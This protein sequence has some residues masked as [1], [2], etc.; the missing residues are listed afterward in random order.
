MKKIIGI[1]MSI[2]LLTSISSLSVVGINASDNK[3][4]EILNTTGHNVILSNGDYTPHENIYIEGDDEFTVENGV[5]GGSGTKG[6]PYVIEG[7]KISKIHVYTTTAYFVI[8]NCYFDEC[9]TDAIA[10]WG[11]TNG[12]VQN[13]TIDGDHEEHQ[14]HLG[15]AIDM[16]NACNNI[17]ENCSITNITLAG[18]RLHPT[19]LGPSNNNIIRNCTISNCGDTTTENTAGI[20]VVYSDSYSKYNM[21]YHNNF[22]DNP[23]YNALDILFSGYSSS[24]T[25]WD[26]GMEGNYWDDYDGPDL[27][28]RDGIGDIPYGI[29]HHPLKTKDRF[30]LMKPYNGTASSIQV[31]QSVPQSN[32]SGQPSSQQTTSTSTTSSTSQTLD[33]VET[34]ES[35][36]GQQ[37]AIPEF[38]L[39]LKFFQQMLLHLKLN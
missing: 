18:I 33:I 4:V 12:R 36:S 28:P 13:C 22:I 25:Q 32:P 24:T 9:I 14:V 26:N 19:E 35:I 31:S 10:F 29:P 5:T 37:S 27:F 6:D 2:L 3:N 16:F 15:I 21:I 20:V 39:F 8:R 34:T 7:W 11:V 30:P 1:I 17:I 23:S 38:S